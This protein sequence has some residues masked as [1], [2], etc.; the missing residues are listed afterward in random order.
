MKN[1]EEIIGRIEDAWVLQEL[2]YDTEEVF[3]D[4]EFVQEIMCQRQVNSETKDEV[5]SFVKVSAVT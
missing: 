2:L 4:D 5:N 1:R 3:N